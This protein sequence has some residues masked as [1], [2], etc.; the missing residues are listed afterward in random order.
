MNKYK[1]LYNYLK[2]KVGSDP[3]RIIVYDVYWDDM[4]KIL[5]RMKQFNIQYSSYYVNK[6]KDNIVRYYPKPSRKYYVQPQ[7]KIMAQY[8]HKLMYYIYMKLEEY[9]TTS[10]IDYKI[11]KF[12]N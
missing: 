4:K 9:D 1:F 6:D 8:P 2:I 3:A 11:N 12:L 5:K 10:Y 7:N